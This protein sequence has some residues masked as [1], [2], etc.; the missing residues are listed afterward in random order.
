M[1]ELDQN[2][3]LMIGSQG[4]ILPEH[5][6]FK[7]REDQKAQW[8]FMPEWEQLCIHIRVHFHTWNSKYVKT[9]IIIPVL[10]MEK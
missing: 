3:G 6:A 10:Q 7:M 1:A 8:T 2:V 5:T 4:A 9:D